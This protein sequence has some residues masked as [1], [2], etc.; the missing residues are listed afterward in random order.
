MLAGL[1]SRRSARAVELAGQ[2]VEE[3]ATDPDG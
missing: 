3:A 2:A 1:S